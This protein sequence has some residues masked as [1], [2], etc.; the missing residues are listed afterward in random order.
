MSKRYNSSRMK[1]RPLSEPGHQA[2]IVTGGN[3][4]VHL[5]PPAP[6]ILRSVPPLSS[7]AMAS[8]QIESVAHE[9]GRY[10]LDERYTLKSTYF[11]L[12]L[13]EGVRVNGGVS[14]TVKQASLREQPN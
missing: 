6:P 13:C 10:L 14:S 4:A 1:G 8:P 5:P 9:F 11:S 3:G 12:T 7:S 2:F